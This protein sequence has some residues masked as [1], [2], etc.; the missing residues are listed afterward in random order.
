MVHTQMVGIGMLTTSMV[1][2]T[3]CNTVK[4]TTR[5]IWLMP[6]TQQ[7]MQMVIQFVQT[8]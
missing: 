7:Q 5:L 4:T 1:S 6:Y 2:L 3:E 8:L